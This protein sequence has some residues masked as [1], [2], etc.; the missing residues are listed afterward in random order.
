M[1]ANIL[2]LASATAVGT[3]PHSDAADAAAFALSQQ[4]R[5]PAAPSLPNRTPLERR[6][7]QAAW[8]VAGVDVAA[9]GSLEI[10]L[11]ALD[12]EAPLADPQLTGEPYRG[13]RAFVAALAGRGGPAK[14]QLTGPVTLGVA[15]HAAGVPIGLAFRVA[16]SVVG[17]RATALLSLIEAEAPGTL[18]VV[19]VDEPSLGEATAED[20]P[21]ATEDAVDAVSSALATLEASGALTGLRCGEAA[22]WALVLAA[23]PDLVTLPA[24]AAVLNHAG[25]LGQ[26]LERDGLVVWGAVPTEGPVGSGVD[27]L[28]RHLAGLW[29]SLVQNGVDPVRLRTQALVSPVGGLGRYHVMQAAAVLGLVD[30]LAVRL[31]DQATG[32]RLSVGA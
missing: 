14:F 22:D 13:L 16:E 21:L 9:D 8:G 5:L 25:L 6:V 18:P 7:P 27:R 29:C 3:L 10:D 19:V 17:Q 30:E 4:P 23:G 12:P 24:T 26:F 2:P 11:G 28:W 15:L 31:Y 1:A 32:L 20:F